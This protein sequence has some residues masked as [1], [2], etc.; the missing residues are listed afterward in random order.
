[1][2]ARAFW[3]ALGATLALTLMAVGLLVG[4]AMGLES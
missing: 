3:M 4:T 2:T 1:M